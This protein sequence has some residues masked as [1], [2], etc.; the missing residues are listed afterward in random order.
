MAVDGGE[1]EEQKNHGL[2]AEHGGDGAAH[3]ADR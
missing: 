1:W 2:K 3:D